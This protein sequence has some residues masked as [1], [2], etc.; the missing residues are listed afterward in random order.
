M[1]IPVFVLELQ[2]CKAQIGTKFSCVPLT[3]IYV[4][5]E[6]PQTWIDTPDVLTAHKFIKILECLII[7]WVCVSQFKVIL[8]LLVG[9]NTWWIILTSSYLI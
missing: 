7:F 4:Y 6:C 3:P 1:Q 8:M 9:E 2:Q 5:K